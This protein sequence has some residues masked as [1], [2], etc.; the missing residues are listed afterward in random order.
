MASHSEQVALTLINF[1]FRG[2]KSCTN[3]TKQQK[4]KRAKTPLPSPLLPVVT[5]KS[6]GTEMGQ[7]GVE[8]QEWI[9]QVMVST[10]SSY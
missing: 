2:V 6:V 10:K 3:S 7:K 5:L 4:T 8:Q 9:P 1:C